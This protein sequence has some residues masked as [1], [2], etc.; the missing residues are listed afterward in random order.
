MTNKYSGKISVNVKEWELVKDFKLFHNKVKSY[1]IKKYSKDQNII[2]DIG[3]GR[4]SDVQY[5]YI[6]NVGFLIGIEPSPESIRK[7]VSW[8]L[9]TKKKYKNRNRLKVAYLNGVGHKDWGSG[10]ASL[11]NDDISKFVHY[12]QIK[13]IRANT[14]N[15]FWT[16]HYM[17]DCKKDYDILMN[18]INKHILIN[19]KLVILCMDGNKIHNLLQKHN[20]V[21]NINKTVN[22]KHITIFRI[23]SKYDHNA[24]ITD[25]SAFG[26]KINIYIL[27]A[28][29]LNKGI[30]E[31]IVFID[32][33]AH[34]IK[35]L[36]FKLIEH[37]N[38]VDVKIPEFN[39][40]TKEDIKVP[41]L[42]TSLIFEKIL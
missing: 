22:G 8:Y 5:H 4:G 9:K 17:M 19:S 41:D 35:T 34:N 20:G 25:L 15:M 10:N 3:S 7:A 23:T 26:N 42:Y 37:T 29:G 27:S 1:Y 40:L 32:K 11:N 14:I 2:I 12:F 21:Y 36:K 31:N 6:N 24:K 18:N 30:D 13:K 33:L 38:F 16:I 28:Y 39:I